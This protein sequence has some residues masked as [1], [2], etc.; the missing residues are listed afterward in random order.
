MKVLIV[1][2]GGLVTLGGA[3]ALNLAGHSAP[4]L[5]IIGAVLTVGAGLVLLGDGKAS[6]KD[7]P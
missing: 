3:V 1:F 7:Q 2:A 5:W 6:K 4:G